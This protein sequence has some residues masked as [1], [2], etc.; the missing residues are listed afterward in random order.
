MA[1]KRLLLHQDADD[2]ARRLLR[3]ARAF[4]P[5]PLA[6]ERAMAAARWAPPG[7]SP[8]RGRSLE[9][10]RG[11]GLWAIAWKGA[12]VLTI[13]GACAVL[14][15]TTRSAQDRGAAPLPGVPTTPVPPAPS[16]PA[17]IGL[18]P[19]EPALIEPAPIR[20]ARASVDPPVPL[21]DPGPKS[22]PARAK[23]SVT[24][25]APSLAEEVAAIDAAR[26]AMGRD[27]PRGALHLLDDYDH[28][29]PR[30]TFGPESR[31]LRVE[32]LVARGDRATAVRSARAI[33]VADPEGSEAA[34]LRRLLGDD[35][36]R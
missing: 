15:G 35:L 14:Q 36:T 12:V 17:P 23:P 20:P 24:S 18:A 1:V 26:L 11:S 25:P 9:P 34:R 4:K 6:R 19:T 31:M 7:A 33:V 30:G 22:G 10:A 2:G 32:A 5:S 28:R 29:F 8:T 16:A 21:E 27:D 13:A 3:A